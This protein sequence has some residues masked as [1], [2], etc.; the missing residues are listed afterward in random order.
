MMIACLIIPQLLQAGQY[1]SARSLAMAQSFTSLARNYQTLGV[2][3]ANL[4]FDDNDSWSLEF[5]SAGLEM[6]NN[7]FSFKD[8]NTYNGAHLSQ[9]DK[10]DIL[11][12]IPDAGLEGAVQTGA[13]ALCMSF[14]NFAFG[15]T[16]NGDGS[17]NLDK[18]LVELMFN[19]NAIGDT[20]NVTDAFGTGVAHVDFNLSYGA[21]LMQTK[22]GVVNWGVNFKYIMGVAYADVEEAEGVLITN[23]G[24]LDSDGIAKVKTAQGGSGFGLDLGF[25]ARVNDKYNMSLALT[26]LIGTIKWNKETELNT[27]IFTVDNLSLDNAEDDSTVTSDDITEE[28]DAFNSSL[29]PQLAFG[30]SRQFKSLLVSF[31][32]KQGFKNLGLISTTPEFSLGCEAKFINTIPLRLG[33]S[34]GGAR[35]SSSSLGLGFNLNPFYFDIAYVATGTIVPFGGK[36]KGLA[37]SSGLM[38]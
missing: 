20:V 29:A 31:D 28:I 18:K 35:G 5:F 37:V 21:K 7:S 11:S 26:N 13:S 32:Y 3:P 17:V 25:S 14:G 2:N 16:G 30:I 9:S 10:D 22:W 38:F 23:D 27:Y 36:G 8:Y 24:G 1:S 15:V 34:A 33:F 6:S 19:G 4:A 12:K